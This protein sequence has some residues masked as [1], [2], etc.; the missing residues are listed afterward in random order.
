MSEMH[1]RQPRFTYSDCGPFTKTKQRMKN[2]KETGDS[3][4]SYQNELYKACFQ[5][6]TGQL[7]N[8]ENLKM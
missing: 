8:M 7:D 3:K 5:L 6:D 2:I 1:L 4:C